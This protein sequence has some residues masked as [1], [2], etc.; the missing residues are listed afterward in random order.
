MKEYTNKD[1]GTFGENE[2][3]KYVKKVKKYKILGKNVTIG[4]LEADIIAY[5]KEH[6]III[7]VRTRREDKNNPFRPAT[8][9][10]YSKQSNLINFAYAYVKSLPK[11]FDGKSIRIDVCEI[12]AKVDEKLTLRSLNYIENAVTR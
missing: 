12:T 8:A 9:V 10:N 2:C 1:V 7:E 11:R 5:D 6:I 4:H 3:L